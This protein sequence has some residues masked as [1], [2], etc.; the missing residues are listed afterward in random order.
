MRRLL[1]LAAIAAVV[2]VAARSPAGA[3]NGGPGEGDASTNSL[4]R[5]SSVAPVGGVQA[6]SSTKPS[7]CE[8]ILF[9][10]R[11]LVPT[12]PELI[13]AAEAVVVGELGTHGIVRSQSSDGRFTHMAY[14]FTVTDVLRGQ[15]A[16]GAVVSLAG[17]TLDATGCIAREA[18]AEPMVP[19]G[20]YLAF[21]APSPRDDGVYVAVGGPQGLFSV[22]ADGTLVPLAPGAPTSVD[23]AG[24]RVSEIAARL[25][26]EGS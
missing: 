15:V 26:V 3:T 14:E 19:G 22:G 5:A 13:A 20:R 6:A 10:D 23:F 1:S 7:I 9:V 18:D 2:V 25:S 4:P 21:I 8:S 11:A 12:T 24:R 16:E 17:V